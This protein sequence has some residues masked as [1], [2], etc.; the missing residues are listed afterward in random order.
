MA[1]LMRRV[2][3][4]LA[5]ACAACSAIAGLDEDYVVETMSPALD[6]GSDA[7]ADATT[8][9]VEAGPPDAGPLCTGSALFCADFEGDASIDSE[10]SRTEATG[11]PPRIVEGLGV[12]ASR[13][14]QAVMAAPSSGVTAA[15]VAWRTVATDFPVGTTL[16]LRFVFVVR[17]KETDY[18]AIAVIQFG[19]REHGLAMYDRSKCGVING[20]CLDENDPTGRPHD[21]NGAIP[22]VP[23]VWHT[24]LVSLSRSATGY[25]G[26]VE[27]DGKAVDEHATNAMPTNASTSKIEVGI[28]SFFSSGHG[29]NDVVVDDVVVTRE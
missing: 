26:R 20:P 15:T 23:G 12:G 27:I 16:T 21:A 29:T 6:A 24:G 28:G 4:M 5:T 13:A 25:A 7:A 2:L 10:F 9:P 19:E 18:A 11:G 14:F 1:L 8:P 17:A 3:A 22:L